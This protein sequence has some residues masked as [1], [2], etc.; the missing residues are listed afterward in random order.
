[1][2]CIYENVRIHAKHIFNVC[3]PACL[4]AWRLHVYMMSANV[5]AHEPRKSWGSCAGLNVRAQKIILYVCTLAACFPALNAKNIKSL[6]KCSKNSDSLIQNV[7]PTPMEVTLEVAMTGKR[8]KTQVESAC[9][10]CV[11]CMP[12]CPVSPNFFF[13]SELEW[14][15]MASVRFR[16]SLSRSSGMPLYPLYA[17]DFILSGSEAGSFLILPLQHGG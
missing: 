15:W 12:W 7:Q 11:H 1:V 13:S 9:M 8:K 2:L 3:K 6:Q 10:L 16:E 14:R 5:V 4:H 17:I